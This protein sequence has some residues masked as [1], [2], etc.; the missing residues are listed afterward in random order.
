MDIN[1]FYNGK[2]VLKEIKD[3]WISSKILKIIFATIL[4]IEVEIFISMALHVSVEEKRVDLF[5]H[6]L[7]AT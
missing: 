4:E 6:Y 7:L 1:F 5:D 2:R 3:Y